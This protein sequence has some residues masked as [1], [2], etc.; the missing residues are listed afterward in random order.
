MTPFTFCRSKP[1]SYCASNRGYS[2]EAGKAGHLVSQRH[3]K[4]HKIVS[5]LN[6]ALFLPS[7]YVDLSG[8][9]RPAVSFPS[10]RIGA[11]GVIPYQSRDS[12]RL[13]FPPQSA[14][15]LYYRRDQDAAP[16]EGSICLRVTSKNAPASFDNG[17]DLLLPSGLPW[18]IILPQIA[19]HAGLTAL[20]AQLLQENLVT[21]TQ[22]SR[23]RTILGQGYI[24]PELTLFRLSQEF[25]I[26]FSGG[27][28]LTTV[29]DV[30]HRFQLNSPLFIWMDNHT[31]VD[32]P[33][34]GS[35]L[36]CFEPSADPRHSGRR[37]IH[38]RI[39]KIIDPVSSIVDQGTLLKPEAGELLTRLNPHSRTF[40]PWKYHLDAKNNATS[41]G[42]RALW[43]NSRIS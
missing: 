3:P 33:W 23:C 39:T 27:L 28:K 1:I 40:E 18:R 20:R 21:E 17:H 13:P 14:G 42:L 41:T 43:N 22:L 8:K 24:Y 5:T 35:G 36:A 32:Y 15:F 10:K 30:M 11:R 38:M 4:R 16:L 31:R 2:V 19:C 9:T 12:R 25:P 37:V 7:D 29:G 6:P 26:R 34:A